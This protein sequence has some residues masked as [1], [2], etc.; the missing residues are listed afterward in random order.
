MAVKYYAVRVGRKPG[1]Y[2][3]WD[4][5]KAQVDGFGGAK[6]KSFKSIAEAEDFINEG[7]E[8]NGLKTQEGVMIAY[9]DGSYE[10]SIE[11]FS[12]GINPITLSGKHAS[13]PSMAESAI[14]AA[15]VKH[16]VPLG[17]KRLCSNPFSEYV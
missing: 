7:K 1:I 6:Y 5:C 17:H 2:N 3:T 9:V 4:E 11:T 10:H 8:E 13:I 15:I 16:K 14:L 12:Y